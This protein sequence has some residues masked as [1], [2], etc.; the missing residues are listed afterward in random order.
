MTN[1]RI[2]EIENVIEEVKKLDTTTIE[3]VRMH[4]ILQSILIMMRGMQTEI[5]QLQYNQNRRD[6]IGPVPTPQ[7]WP[8]LS[9]NDWPR[10][11]EIWCA[12]DTNGET[13]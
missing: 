12:N 9:P 3:G 13:K 5:D 6:Y 2:E 1:K 8:P 10:P 11:I 4:A 7:W